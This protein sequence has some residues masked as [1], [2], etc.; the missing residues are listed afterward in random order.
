MFARALPHAR[1]AR[2]A[3]HCAGHPRPSEHAGGD[4]GVHARCVGCSIAWSRSW[5]SA[6]AA[7]RPSEWRWFEPTLTYDNAHSAARAVRRL[8]GDRR[9]GHA[10]R[11]RASRSSFSRRCAFDGDQLQLV[12]NTGW[13]SRGGEKAQRR[14]AGHRRGG[15]RARVPLRVLGDGGS[16]LFAPHARGVR[17]VP[18]RQPAWRAVVRLRHGRLPRRHGRGAR[19]PEPRRR[20]HDLLLDVAAEDA[21]ARR[22]GAR[23]HRRRSRRPPPA[24]Q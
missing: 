9:A 24:V 13:H 16:A 2:A 22:R 11:S 12:G 15:L 1:R 7:T 6:I 14:R 21:G 4:A 8:L 20:E 23:A 17:V 19:Q 5:P 10:A 18:R 3:R